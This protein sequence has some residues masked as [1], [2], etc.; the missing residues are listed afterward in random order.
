MSISKKVEPLKLEDEFQT[1][2]VCGY[3]M[4]F[5]LS[6]KRRS[7]NETNVLLIC[8]QCGARFDIGLTIDIPKA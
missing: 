8:P 7:K 3:D 5:H 6:F 2:P 1:C 4:G